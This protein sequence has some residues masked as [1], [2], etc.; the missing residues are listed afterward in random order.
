MDQELSE[1]LRAGICPLCRTPTAD[2]QPGEG[3]TNG[4]HNYC[5]LQ[6]VTGHTV[7]ACRCNAKLADLSDR[8]LAVEAESRFY[9]ME[10]GEPRP[11]ITCPTCNRTSHNPND[12]NER[13]CG[14]CHNWHENM[15]G[16]LATEAEQ[17][18]SRSQL[19]R[20]ERT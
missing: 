9:E 10:K 11:S 6:N 15:I 16:Q 14:N 2:K 20:R 17:G 1:L 3:V 13:Y 18:Y 5:C 19:R 8:Q 7:G 12:V 4:M